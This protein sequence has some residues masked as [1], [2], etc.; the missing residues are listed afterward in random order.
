MS[1]FCWQQV[2]LDRLAK[3]GGSS[4]TGDPT[5]NVDPSRNGVEPDITFTGPGDTVGW[6]VWYEKDPSNIGL[7]DNEQV[8]AAKIVE[9]PNADGGFHWQA[10][11]N[12]TEARSTS[13]T[14]R[15]RASAR[16]RSRPTPRTPAR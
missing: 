11:G 16:A 8:F 12:G 7:R 5:L 1:N 14:R 10:V 6:T 13:S 4:P 15:A 9:D 2:G 3:D